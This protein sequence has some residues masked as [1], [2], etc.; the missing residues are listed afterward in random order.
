[1]VHV[2]LQFCD[3]FRLQLFLF[4]SGDRTASVDPGGL[5]LTGHYSF[6]DIALA[7]DHL[8][9]ELLELQGG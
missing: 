1:M 3:A 8:D 5:V 7:I 9:A 2:K 4:F 6:A